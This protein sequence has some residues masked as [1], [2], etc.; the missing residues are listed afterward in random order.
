MCRLVKRR[1]TAGHRRKDH[2]Q[3]ALHELGKCPRPSHAHV[4]HEAGRR[5]GTLLVPKARYNLWPSTCK[6]IAPTLLTVLTSWGCSAVSSTCMPATCEGCGDEG[7]VMSVQGSVTELTG[8]WGQKRFESQTGNRPKK[9]FG[10]TGDDTVKVVDSTSTEAVG[11]LECLGR[12]LSGVLDTR[13]QTAAPRNNIA[14]FTSSHH[15]VI[16]LGLYT[17][18]PGCMSMCV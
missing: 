18:T 7:A 6:H 2:Q 1:C 12:S 14:H 10:P 4:A 15:G 5:K 17:P 11:Q 13:G 8:V 3:T 9:R 16:V